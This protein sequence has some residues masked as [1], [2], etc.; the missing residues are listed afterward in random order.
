MASI[1]SPMVLFD[2]VRVH[3][4]TF[5]LKS[6][7]CFFVCVCAIMSLGLN[8]SEMIHVQR[9]DLNYQGLVVSLLMEICDL[10]PGR[11]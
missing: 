5:N 6:K 8:A 1:F 9:F 7:M 3:C 4:S 2:G 10:V 11:L